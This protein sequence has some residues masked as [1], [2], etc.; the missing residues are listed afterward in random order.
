M[1]HE[2]A[3]RLKSLRQSK[4]LTQKQIAQLFN[5][6]ERGYQNYEIGKSTPNV[7]LL[8]AL[9]EFF[10]VPVGFLSG[11]SGADLTKANLTMADMR[12]IKACGAVFR[13]ANLTKANLQNAD[14]RWADFTSANLHGANFEG[15]NLD[16]AIFNGADVSGTILE[17]KIVNGRYSFS[18]SDND[19]KTHNHSKKETD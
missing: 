9:A 10:E 17:G 1:N 13:K 19:T 2:F 18:G 15:A 12:Q 14:L 11:E 16:G 5:L 8:L 4:N 7:S 6:T 3:T